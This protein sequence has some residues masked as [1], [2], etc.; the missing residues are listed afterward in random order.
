M[1]TC[2][3]GKRGDDM[4]K[5]IRHIADTYLNKQLDM[6]VRIFNVMAASGM[7]VSFT[8]AISAVSTG[9][10]WQECLMYLTFALLSAWLLWFATK[11]G[12]FRLCYVVTI[13]AIFLGGFSVFFL[14]GGGYYSSMPY[15]FVF[16]V[17]FTIF[18]LEGRSA[19][20]MA[21]I[22]LALYTSLCLYRYH[23]LNIA[24]AYFE[25]ESILHE[26]LFGFILVSAALGITMFV[27][28][29]LYSE[30]QKILNEHNKALGRINQMKTEL[31]ANVS[32]EMKTPLTV[33]SVHVQ[34]AEAF[35]KRGGEKDFEKVYESFA[36][37]QKEI[38]RLSR[39]VEGSLAV[40][41]MQELSR[42]NAEID[43]AGVLR[44][45]IDAYRALSEKHSNTLTLNI[46]GTLPKLSVSTDALVQMITNLLANANAHTEN[47]IIKVLGEYDTTRAMLKISIKDNGTGIASEL[48]PNVFERGITDGSGN[49][50]GLAICRDVARAYGGD[51]VIESEYGKGTTAVITLP[52]RTED[53]IN[54]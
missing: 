8:S 18:M 29:R 27:Q 37:V 44:S 41:S 16:A 47:D 13:V 39:M 7:I 38:M 19:V 9:D 14:S 36:V 15:F 3:E 24:P 43:A 46:S 1:L 4:K 54:G 23:H 30:Q 53:S 48:L 33:I 10:P 31:F 17:V 2:A 32:H 5:L 52:V 49:G 50:F 11:T 40:S 34:R 45:S 28:L 21:V 12:R 42:R 35:M 51:V 6:R 25:S 26:T 20:I 22:E